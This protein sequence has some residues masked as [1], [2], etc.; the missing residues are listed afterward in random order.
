MAIDRDK[1]IDDVRT[2]LGGL[3][4]MDFDAALAVVR[5]VLVPCGAAVLT[6][7]ELADCSEQAEEAARL[8]TGLSPASVAEQLYDHEWTLTEFG[9]A[10]ICA[11]LDGLTVVAAPLDFEGRWEVA[12]SDRAAV[13]IGNIRGLWAIVND[14][15]KERHD[16]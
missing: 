8:R 9:P 4:R 14:I 6:V 12:V 3:A 5:S 15:S 1:S 13:A 16:G 10:R 2:A 7:E 11:T